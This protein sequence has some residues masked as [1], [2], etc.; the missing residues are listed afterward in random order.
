MF[1]ILNCIRDNHDP[2]QLL[3]A[4]LTCCFGSVISVGLGRRAIRINRKEPARGPLIIAGL[5]TGLTIW[6]THFSAMLAYAPGI[7]IRFNGPAMLASASLSILLAGC[8]WFILAAPGRTRGLLGGGLIG[9]GLC[10][11]HFIDMSALRVNGLVLYDPR[12]ILLAVALGLPLCIAAGMLARS[13]H[14]RSLALPAAALAAGTLSLHL[15]AMSAIRIIPSQMETYSAL[16]LGIEGLTLLVVASSALILLMGAGLALHDLELSRATAA[17]RERLRQSEEHHRYSVELSPHIPWIADPEGQILEISPR[18]SEVVGEPVSQAMGFGWTEKVHPE[19]LPEVLSVWQ[20]VIGSGDAGTADVRYR[21]LQQ[22]GS[23]RWFR[24]RARPRCDETGAILL[25]YGSLED[26]DE[27]VDAELALRASE[28]RYR[29]ASLATNDVIWDFRSDSDI[30]QWNGAVEDVLGYPEAKA[31]TSRSW[32]IERLHPDERDQVLAS[33]R[34]ILKSGAES[35][36]Q[37]FRFRTGSGEYVDLLSRGHAVRDETGKPTRLVGSLIDITARKRG[38]DELRWAA[39]HDPLTR[40]PNRKL[41]S[42][43]LDTALVDAQRSGHTIG[44]VVIDVDGFKSLND[45]LGHAAGDAALDVIASR[46]TTGIPA[47]ATVAR[48]GGDEFAIILPLL[49]DP[50][51]LQAPLDRILRVMDQRI[52]YEGQQIEVS[53]SVGA[54]TFPADGSDSESL[55]KS[56]D[57]AL[58]A[59]K[60][61]G[62]GNAR[63][64]QPAMRELAEVERQM[65]ANARAALQDHQIIPYYQPKICLR[66]GALVGFEALLRWDSPDREVRPPSSIQAAFVDPRLAPELTDRMLSR[67]ATDMAA[68]LDRGQCF[69]RIA[70]NG[71]PEDFRRGDLANRILEGLGAAGV[72]PAKFELEITETVFLGKHAE[73][74]GSTLQALR[75]EGV[76]IALDDFGTGYASLTHLKQFPVDV[77]KIDQSFVSRLVSDK[78]QDAAIVAALIDLAKNLGIQTVAEGVETGLQAFMLR[79]RGCDIGQGYFFQRPLAADDALRFMREWKPD[80]VLAELSDRLPVRESRRQSP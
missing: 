77:L 63:R 17:D 49:P 76:T 2:L 71:S 72:D 41:F 29:L 18:W 19:D 55:L 5:A 44:L 73:D 23:W 64:F 48:L 69:G 20:S 16:D 14:S 22:D 37:E 78:Q 11:A 45:T 60:A 51:A 38:E 35:W 53:L 3:I 56:A 79:R 24:A 6:S 30:V 27:Q 75:S 58:Y 50:E 43:K 42:L 68:W 31:G 32:W 7:F 25:W 33:A 40:L 54:A 8:G 34:E 15:V 13:G 36:T 65:R 10:A 4:F 62:A 57:L 39:H 47:N 52:L 1:E 61:A 28:E 74:V 26:I 70:M 9:L 59:A 66:T 21:L 80:Q 67:I 12:L 46:L